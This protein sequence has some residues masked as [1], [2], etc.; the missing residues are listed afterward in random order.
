MFLSALLTEIGMSTP[1]SVAYSPIQ[2]ANTY[3]L[4]CETSLFRYPPRVVKEYYT[5]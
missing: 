2:Y 4:T 1:R 3:F 5:S